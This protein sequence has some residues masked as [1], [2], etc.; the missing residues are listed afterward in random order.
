M[1]IAREI[2]ANKI[3]ILATSYLD[4]D[5]TL[6]SHIKHGAGYDSIQTN[7]KCLLHWWRNTE[8]HNARQALCDKLN[9]AVKDGL[10]SQKGA[11]ILKGHGES[12]ELDNGKN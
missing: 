10:V 8:E 2:L 3:D 9:T 7:F 12:K 6:L 1:A 5:D 4:I 11:D